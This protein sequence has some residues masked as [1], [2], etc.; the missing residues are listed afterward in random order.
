MPWV[1]HQGRAFKNCQIL[2]SKRL[3]IS[4]KQITTSVTLFILAHAISIP[5]TPYHIDLSV[6]A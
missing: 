4:N 2:V 5:L 1:H 3:N 6:L